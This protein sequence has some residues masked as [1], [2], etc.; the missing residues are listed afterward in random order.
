MAMI[1]RITQVVH[2]SLT[3]VQFP[4]NFKNHFSEPGP[5]YGSLEYCASKNPDVLDY[6]P[7]LCDCVL[8]KD[9]ELWSM[10]KSRFVPSSLRLPFG[11][12]EKLIM[13]VNV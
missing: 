10:E 3:Q 6:Y 1:V 11:I 8:E 5:C 7:I 9:T 4:L 13:S 12:H 2:N